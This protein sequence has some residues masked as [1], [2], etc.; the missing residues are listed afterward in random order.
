MYMAA[1]S[2]KDYFAELRAHGI[3]GELIKEKI[4]LHFGW[5]NNIVFYGRYYCDKAKDAETAKEIFIK[6]GFNY[7]E[8]SGNRCIKIMHDNKVNK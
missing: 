7:C 2:K 4:P 1:H 3:S 5:Y 8:I 6:C